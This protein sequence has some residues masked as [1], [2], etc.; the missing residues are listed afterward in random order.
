MRKYV[1]LAAVALLT[2]SSAVGG[3]RRDRSG[4]DR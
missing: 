1:K 2:G 4:G 3:D